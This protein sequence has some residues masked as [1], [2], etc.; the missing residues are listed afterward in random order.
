MVLPFFK[1]AMAGT[2]MA[3]VVLGIQTGWDAL[4][5]PLPASIMEYAGIALASAVGLV[6]YTLLAWLFKVEEAEYLRKRLL[7]R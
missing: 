5:L 6:V 2:L 3:G 4:S 7:K 1:L